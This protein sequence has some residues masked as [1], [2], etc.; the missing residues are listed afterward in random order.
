MKL[1][2]KTLIPVCLLVIFSI[3]NFIPGFSLD[4]IKARL[5]FDN[6]IDDQN[7]LDAPGPETQATNSDV[8]VSTSIQLGEI[9]SRL[10][11][12]ELRLI[13]ANLPEEKRQ[14]ILVEPEVFLKIVKEQIAFKSVIRVVLANQIH[15]VPNA[16]FLMQK[17][18]EN[19]LRESYIN[20]LVSQQLPMDYP[21]DELVKDFYE[22]NSDRFV[23]GERLHLWQIYLPFKENISAGEIR[24][25]ED[26]ADTIRAEIMNEKL[27]FS[28]AA[29]QYSSHSPSRENGGYMGLVA[30]SDLTP[31]VKDRVLNLQ[32]NE[33]SQPYKTED[34]IH[35]LKH[36]TVVAA[37]SVDLAQVRGRIREVLRKQAIEKLRFTI[38]EQAQKAQP[39]E[40]TDKQIEEWRLKLRTSL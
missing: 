7:L 25:L 11:L 9:P 36:G 27:N 30:L 38:F 15:A 39:S 34:G 37:Q 23:L 2:A 22:K 26:K 28:E 29:K 31:V 35:L 18:A 5:G 16:Q 3:M 14:E 33:L 40:L 24:V 13:F 10:E 1:S 17:A 19:T 12:D 4:E 20:Q 6:E 32:E 21:D 8:Q